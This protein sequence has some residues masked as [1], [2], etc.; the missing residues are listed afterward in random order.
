MLRRMEMIRQLNEPLS[1]AQIL[2]RIASSRGVVAGRFHAAC[3]S[4]LAA[5]PFAAMSS[6][7]S[8]SKGMLHDAGVAKFLT[9]DAKLAFH[10]INVWKEADYLAVAAYIEKARRDAKAMFEDIAGLR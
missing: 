7:T 5:T 10:L 3:M 2:S 9:D 1:S 6:N 4:M 8:K